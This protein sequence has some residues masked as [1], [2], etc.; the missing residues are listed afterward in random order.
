MPSGTPKQLA[1]SARHIA[2]EY[3]R[4]KKL[5]ITQKEFAETTGLGSA[6]Y[7]RKILAGERSGRILEKRAA[8]GGAFN[9]PISYK[10][11]T[12][13]TTQVRLPAGTSR[14]DVYQPRVQKRIRRSIQRA[15]TEGKSRA[16]PPNQLADSQVA[17]LYGRPQVGRITRARRVR[18]M[19]VAVLRDQ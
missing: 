6:R 13:A 9:V 3:A 10:G 15:Q 14:L 11:E 2:R 18:Q 12:S 8:E 19:P 4:A 1:P 17:R 7:L 5:G 16:K